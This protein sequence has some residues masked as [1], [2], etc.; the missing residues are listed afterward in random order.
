MKRITVALV[1]AVTGCAAPSLDKP[2]LARFHQQPGGFQFVAKGGTWGVYSVDSA[3]AET[4]RL[5]QGLREYAEQV[6]H[7]MVIP[8][9]V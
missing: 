3:N 4:I 2:Y 5:R 7:P 1:I 6:F 8:S 9:P